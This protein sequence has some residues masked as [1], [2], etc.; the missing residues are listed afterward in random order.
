MMSAAMVLLL[1]A[2]SGGLTHYG[3]E[4]WG[5]V[6]KAGRCGMELKIPWRTSVSP[7][8]PQTGTLSCKL[9][10]GIKHYRFSA[11]IFEIG[12]QLLVPEN[13]SL[14]GVAGPN[15]MSKPT[16]SPDWSGQ[17]LFLATRGATD[18]NMNYCHAKD[19]VTTRVGFVLSSHVTVRN[20]SYQGID[21]IRPGQN[22]ALCGGG[23]FETKGCAENDCKKSAVNNGGSDGMG[24]VGVTID[25]VRLNDYYRTEDTPKIGPGKV[26]GNYNCSAGG[27]CF[28]KPNGVR[29]SQ[30]GVW[31]PQSRDPGGTRSLLVK[32]LVSSAT[33]ADGINLHGYIKDALIQDTH[34]S[35]TGD[36][37]YA[38]WGGNLSPENVTWSRNVAV[39]TGILRPGWYGNCFA[40]YGLKSVLIEDMT[41][42]NPALLHRV[43]NAK[44]AT[45]L[46]DVSMFVFYTSF[47][48]VYPA[49]NNVTIK[50]WT[51]N[52][53][54]GRPYT[55]ATGSTW[56]GKAVPGK[57]FWMDH[58]PYLVRG[59]KQHVNINFIDGSTV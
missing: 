8:E 36:D 50:G 30:V 13:T 24:S 46:N 12:E 49:G 58:K 35:D 48:G 2:A 4:S 39:N 1:P 57:M 20:I 38:Q 56:G 14:T 26:A 23:A 27:C 11:G 7:A 37:T 17:T 45:D 43:R 29:A 53:M 42:Q 5:A 9:E 41:C 55:A 3:Y 21:T 52:D 40:T 16:K 6:I 31:A 51:F 47:G 32:N 15:D 33:Q 19:M 28:C 59:G 10:G 44:G 22:G 34:I 25:N 18:Y 54:H